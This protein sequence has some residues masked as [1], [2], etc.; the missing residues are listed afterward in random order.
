VLS[1]SNSTLPLMKLK[2]P[3]M[4]PRLSKKS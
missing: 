2:R 1:E 4:K 3:R